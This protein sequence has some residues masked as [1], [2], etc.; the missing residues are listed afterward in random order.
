MS[1]KPV[2]D[3][4]MSDTARRTI[5]V[6]GASRGLGRHICTRAVEEGWNV[7]GLARTVEPLDGVRMIACDVGDAEDVAKAFR[8]IRKDRNFYA[9]INGAGIASMNLMFTTP[10]ATIDRII[11]V[12]LLGTMYCSQQAGR[13]LARRGEGRI[14][15]FSTLANSIALKGE[16]VYA[17]SKAGVEGFSRTFA[18][19]MADFG[20]TVNCI[21][22]GPI[23]TALIAKVPEENIR[24][25]VSHQIIQRKAEPEDVWNVTSLLLSPAANWVTGDVDVI[26]LGG[27]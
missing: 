18:R 3:K 4:T 16:A 25:I 15:N 26:H 20:I 24:R 6:T 17:A 8:E 14:I 9:L 5:V 23:D 27:V 2:S 11:R 21:S 19:E 13:L 22:P 7:I 10:P 12:N 1:D